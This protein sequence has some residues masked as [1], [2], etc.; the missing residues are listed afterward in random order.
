VWA[1]EAA[2]DKD[3]VVV[4]IPEKNVPDLPG[5]LFDGGGAHYPVVIDTCNNYPQSRDGRIDAIEDG[6]PESRW[7]E[8][9]IGHP[10]VKAFNNIYFPHLREHGRPADDPARI[11]LPV[12][13]DEAESKAVVMRL[14]E[15]LG[16]DPVDAGGLDESWRQQP[17]TGVYTTDLGATDLRRALSEADPRRLPEWSAAGAG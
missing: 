11:A 16:F 13:G 15:E 6:M 2:R 9:R 10:V 17:G 5:G 1:R 4:T 8:R 3:V 7:V 12:A 14:V